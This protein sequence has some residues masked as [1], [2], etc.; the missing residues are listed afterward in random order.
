VPGEPDYD[1]TCNF[2]YYKQVSAS[3]LVT[4]PSLHPISV[5][6]AQA[7]AHRDALCGAVSVTNAND[8][9]L[10]AGTELDWLTF[11]WD[12]TTS[13]SAP[14]SITVSELLGWY[15]AA[16]VDLTNAGTPRE[17]IRVED[18]IAKAPAS[19]QTFLTQRA[20]THAVHDPR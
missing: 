2:V 16:L 3:N 1:G 7:Y 11:Y 13:S 17:K 20:E 10:V 9:A 12:I 15:S 18:V 5:N 14:A 19:L 4:T 8:A 6:C